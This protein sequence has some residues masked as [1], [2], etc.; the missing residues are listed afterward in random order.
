MGRVD[1][2]TLEVRV[3]GVT[4]GR[5]VSFSGFTIWRPV[6]GKTPA[7][8]AGSARDAF[9]YLPHLISRQKD[10]CGWVLAVGNRARK[11]QTS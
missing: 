10:F 9:A 5:A 2:G 8:W 1:L 7:P 6:S 3:S 11:S 4:D